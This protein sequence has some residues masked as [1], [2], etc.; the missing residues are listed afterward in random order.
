MGKQN[1]S[2]ML[3]M[4]HLF[5]KMLT[6]LINDHLAQQD[7]A[8]SP[9]ERQPGED[10]KYAYLYIVLIFGMFTF[11]MVFILASTVKSRRQ[12]H[13]SDSNHSCIGD[14]SSKRTF[15]QMINANQWPANERGSKGQQDLW[16]MDE[17]LTSS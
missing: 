8:S 14:P 15:S 16:E 3:N 10:F 1:S 11:I 7:Q 5:E 13:S 17:T 4:T 9:N 12:E 6:N 2:A